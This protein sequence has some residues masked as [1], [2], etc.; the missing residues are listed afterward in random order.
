MRGTAGL[1]LMLAFN[2]FVFTKAY[3]A[4]A[5]LNNF[6]CQYE[7]NIDT[8]YCTVI[9]QSSGWGWKCPACSEVSTLYFVLFFI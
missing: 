2:A 9:G 7:C 6:V 3:R 8:G 1:I 4:T 5:K